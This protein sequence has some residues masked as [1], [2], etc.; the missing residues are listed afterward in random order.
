MN[1]NDNYTSPL[2]NKVIFAYLKF[3]YLNNL[4]KRTSINYKLQDLGD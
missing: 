4:Y 1:G 3:P 2:L